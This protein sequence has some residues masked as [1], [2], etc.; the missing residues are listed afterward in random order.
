MA[1][2]GVGGEGR[3]VKGEGTRPGAGSGRRR[4]C[5]RRGCRR[6]G[7][8]RGWKRGCRALVGIAPDREFSA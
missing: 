5:R 8:K 6:R 7:W 3:R 1:I 2:P 4:G